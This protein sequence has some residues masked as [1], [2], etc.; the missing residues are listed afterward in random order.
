MLSTEI[1][2]ANLNNCL[3]KAHF[4]ELPNFYSGKVRE[5]YDLPNGLRIIIATDRQSAFDKI[6]AAVPF[7]GQVLNE[8]AKFWFEKTQAICPNHVVEFPDPNVIVAKKL[9]M[10]PLEV[11][12]RNYLT[13][14]S[15]TSIWTAYKNGSREFC[16]NALPDGMRKNQQLAKTI[17]TP[18]TKPA[19]G[20]HDESV[21]PQELIDRGLITREIWE[22]IA[23]ISL[24]LFALGA[25]ISAQ[26]GLILVDTKFEF[27]LAENGEI[28]LADEIF[29]PDSSRYWY[30]K[31]YAA[32]LA[33][34][35]EP[36]SLDKEFLRLWITERCDP[37]QEEIPTIPAAVLVEFSQKYLKL[38]ETV[39]GQ[40]FRPPNLAQQPLERIRQNLAKYF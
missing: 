40:E 3:T 22:Q 23:K 38:F 20:S 19:D 30:Q 31:S 26:N 28:T 5:N 13:G 17:L 27:G 14:S 33:K 29:T 1:I 6:L 10:L 32:R 9:K 11:I 25:K 39:T 7:K 24:E 37:Y 35:L 2:S 16:G 34:D 18:S 36:E 8:T 15:A 12:V 4:P 21:A